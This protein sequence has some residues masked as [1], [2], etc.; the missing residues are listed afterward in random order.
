M[1]VVTPSTLNASLHLAVYVGASAGVK[2]GEAGV[3]AIFFVERGIELSLILV[4]RE[5]ECCVP[6]T[7]SLLTVGHGMRKESRS[8]DHTG[9]QT[10]NPTARRFEVTK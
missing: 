4:A 9:T 6:T 8:C 7:E 2:Q 1:C 5:V 3:L 10:R